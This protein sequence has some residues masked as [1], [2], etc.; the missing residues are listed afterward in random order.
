MSED[1]LYK[2]SGDNSFIKVREARYQKM[3]DKDFA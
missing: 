1:Q 3:W 2:P